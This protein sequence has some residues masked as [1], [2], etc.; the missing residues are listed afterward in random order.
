MLAN[1]ETEK[2]LLGCMILSKDALL[3]T[4]NK[5][6]EIDF[7][8]ELNKQVFATIKKINDDRKVIDPLTI[9]NTNNNIDIAY[10]AELTDAVT[11]P[12][13]YSSHINIIKESSIKTQIL[14][15]NKEIEKFVSDVNDMSVEEIYSQCLSIM[16]IDIDIKKEKTFQQTVIDFLDNLEKKEESNLKYGIPWLD[17]N[18]HGLH[19]ADL[20]YLAARPSCGKTAL[21]LNVATSLIFKGNNV[22]IFSLEMGSEQLLQRISSSLSKITFDKI[23]S[24]NLTSD[25]YMAVF[26]QLGEVSNLNKLEVYDNIFDLERIKVESKKLKNKNKLD[27][28]VID[29]LQLMRTKEKIQNDNSRIEYISRELKL[30]AKELNVPVICL[31]QLSREGANAVPKLNHLR[32]SGAIEQDADVILF[33]YDEKEGEYDEKAVQWKDIQIIIAKQRQG[34]R[35]IA[36]QLRFY[37]D[38]Q[39]FVEVK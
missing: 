27:A 14:N 32:G 7:E 11:Y 31:S 13:S 39:K 22:V 1:T 17:Y 23:R 38:Y 8:N 3:E 28:I 12:D 25:E 6:N 26:N 33:L 35:N 24:K 19:N 4:I 29:Y 5:V 9:C 30:L 15:R 21:A 34:M 36:K 2:A 37:G 16:N 18:T 10:I 20:I